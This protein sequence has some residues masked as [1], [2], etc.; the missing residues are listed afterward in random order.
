MPPWYCIKE[1][2]L[3][4]RSIRTEINCTASTI[5][6]SF[7]IQWGCTWFPKWVDETVYLFIT[8]PLS[9]WLEDPSPRQGTSLHCSSRSDSRPL[10]YHPSWIPSLY[11]LYQRDW[12]ADAVILVK[13]LIAIH[14]N[15]LCVVHKLFTYYLQIKVLWVKGGAVNFQNGFVHHLKQNGTYTCVFFI[16][17]LEVQNQLFSLWTSVD[18]N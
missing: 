10:W 2:K 18:W 15:K 12:S 8:L 6:F 16:V 11:I 7:R 17:I 13:K 14:S 9:L 4:R 1:I 5:P 3:W